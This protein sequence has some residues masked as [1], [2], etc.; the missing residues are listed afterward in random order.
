MLERL[1]NKKSDFIVQAVAEYMQRHPELTVPD[2]HIKIEYRPVQ[3]REQ[4]LDVVRTM[5]KAALEE[6]L[7]GKV[8]LPAEKVPQMSQVAGNGPSEQDLDAMVAGLKLFDM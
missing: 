5:T 4:I 7:E 2:A 1:G 6:L 3:T 8:L